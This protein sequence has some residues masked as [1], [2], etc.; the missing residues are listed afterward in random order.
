[1]KRLLVALIAAIAALM[2]GTASAGQPDICSY[3]PASVS[4][5][6]K[7]LKLVLPEPD[8]TTSET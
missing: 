8:T 6:R 7:K 1:M 2:A 4:Q 3:L 5:A